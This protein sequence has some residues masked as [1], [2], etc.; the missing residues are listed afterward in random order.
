MLYCQDTSF[1][2]ITV[3]VNTLTVQHTE[4]KVCGLSHSLLLVLQVQTVI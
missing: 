4:L 3:H 1:K 2:P